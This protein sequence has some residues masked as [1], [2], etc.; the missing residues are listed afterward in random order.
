MTLETDAKFKKLTC[1]LENDLRNLVNVYQSIWMCQN[2]DFDGI[3]LFKV[4]NV[5][6]KISQR[7]YV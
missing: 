6:F 1:G 3:I 2:C 4:E 5:W 7:S